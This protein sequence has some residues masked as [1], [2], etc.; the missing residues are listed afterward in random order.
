MT[1][2]RA[3]NRPVSTYFAPGVQISTLGAMSAGVQ[4]STP[5]PADVHGDIIQAQVTR[6]CTGASQY[7]ITLNNWYTTT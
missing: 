7:S 5:L 6:V 2:L 3:S 1:Q 4:V